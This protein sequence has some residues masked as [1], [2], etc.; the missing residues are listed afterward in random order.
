MGVNGVTKKWERE[1]TYG[2]KLVENITQAVARDIMAQAMFR[3]EKE[4]YQVAFSVHDE[5]V[6]EVPSTFGNVKEFESILVRVPLWANGCPIK[7][8]GFE[9]IRYRK[10]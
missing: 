5:I 9:T 1:H 6:C 10:D 2:G 3:C 7:A 4:G 8:K